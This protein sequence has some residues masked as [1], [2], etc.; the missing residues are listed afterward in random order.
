MKLESLPP[1]P[2]STEEATQLRENGQFIDLTYLVDEGDGELNALISLL[3]DTGDK[4]HLLG[5]HPDEREW[6]V[7]WRGSDEETADDPFHAADDWAKEAYGAT[8]REIFTM[9]RPE[10]RESA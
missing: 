1:R 7:V 2:L 9:P 4:R 6:Q 10:E 8:S 3:V 5:F